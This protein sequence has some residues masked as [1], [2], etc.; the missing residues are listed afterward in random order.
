MMASNA[1]YAGGLRRIYALEREHDVTGLIHMLDNPIERDPQST[2]RAAAA[3]AL[4][5]LGDPTAGDALTAAADDGSEQVR[6]AVVRAIGFVRAAQAG[7][8]LVE[9]LGDGV[10][11]VRR[12]AALSLGLIAYHDGIPALRKQLDAEDPWT[13]LYAAESLAL[14]GDRDLVT[15]L[16]ALRARDSRFAR[17]RPKRW[18]EL[19]RKLSVAPTSRQ[20][21]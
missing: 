21:S 15:V 6:Y 9:A 20:A 3:A 14:L 7:P 17:G 13:R 8:T 5:R 19:E 10:L 16:P 18:R 12:A 4:G 2:V 1:Q 11:N